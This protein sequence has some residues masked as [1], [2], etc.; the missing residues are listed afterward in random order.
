[1]NELVVRVGDPR[2]PV[3]N[4]Y[5]ASDARV[6]VIRGPLG[7]GKTVG[8]ITGPLMRHMIQ[9]EPNA[10]GVR[11]TKWLAIRNTYSDLMQTTLADFQNVFGRICKVKRGGLE[12][13]TAHVSFSLMTEPG[14]RPRLSLP[15]ARPRG[16]RT[17]AARLPADRR[18]G[19]RDEGAPEGDH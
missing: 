8:T 12:P 18:L 19:Q 15:S 2:N 11:P 1:M 9:Q 14:W 10:A 6:S 13:P 4:A 17:Q 5:M 16:Q 3:L 7:S